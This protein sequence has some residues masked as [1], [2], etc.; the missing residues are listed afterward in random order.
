VISAIKDSGSV[1][2]YNNEEQIMLSAGVGSYKD[3]LGK[4]CP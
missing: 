2:M 4:V 3:D 1:R